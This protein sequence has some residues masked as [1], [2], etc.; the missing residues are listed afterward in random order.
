MR[1]H[2]YTIKKKDIIVSGHITHAQRMDCTWAIIAQDGDVEKLVGLFIDPTEAAC[3]AETLGCP[4]I[5][6]LSIH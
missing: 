1:I 4:R 3:A 2:N 6:N 5:I